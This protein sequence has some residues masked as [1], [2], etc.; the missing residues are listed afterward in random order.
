MS[1]TDR[2]GRRGTLA[3]MALA[4]VAGAVFTLVFWFLAKQ[5]SLPAFST[6]MVTRALAT[7][8]SAAVLVVVGVLLAWWMRGGA[9]PH[10]RRALTYTAAYLSPA[11]LV[12]STTGM[13]LSA[14]R[15]YIDGLQV[16]QAFRTQFLSRMAQTTSLSDMN[17]IDMPTY[18]PPTWF[19]LGG[20]LANLLG[21]PG[22]EVYQPWA[23][24][25]ISA[26][27]C[28]LVPVWQRL[29]GS[30]PAATAIALVSTCLMLQLGPQEPYAI[31]VAL[32][33]PAVS[34][35]ARRALGGSW[36]ATAGVAIFLG[37]SATI[38]TLFTALAA[39]SVVVM[40]LVLAAASKNWRPIAHLVAA[41]TGS[42]L[43]ALITWGPYL[44]AT[45]QNRER[46]GATA[47]HYLPGEGAEFPVPFLAASIVGVLCMVGLVYLVIHWRRPAEGALLLVL[48][49]QY[50]WCL[51]S[52]VFTVGGV[53][54]LGF[55][56]EMVVALQLATAGVMGFAWIRR[57]GLRTLYPDRFSARAQQAV[58][59]ALVVV[60]SF[61]GVKYAQDIPT[62]NQ[63]N[64]DYAYSDTDGYGERADR[65]APNATQYYAQ[66]DQE[67]Q[68]HGHNPADTVVLADETRFMSF[69]PYYGFQAFTSH[70]ANPLGEF[71][72]RNAA[73]EDWATRSWDELADPTTF[74][75]ALHEPAWRA[76]DVF[77]FRGDLEAERD[78]A[79]ETKTGFKLHLAEDIYPNHP[80]VRFKGVFFNPDSFADEKLWDLTQIG[81]FV[82]VTRVSGEAGPGRVVD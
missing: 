17:Y 66:I 11:A 12:F 73:I 31:I 39:G 62:H 27:A 14:T 22:W 23:L 21:M 26:A 40:A 78:A 6:S 47:M 1:S 58:T 74:D 35:I 15:L 53:T 30:L 38:Y 51:A 82:V 18:Y 67:I 59:V 20:R 2:L 77:I 48:L 56:I 49:C 9:I 70:Y 25:S 81:P 44:W 29:L 4:P 69:H 33:V 52:M 37:V 55:R 34:V 57:E 19:W 36:F 76:P 63:E 7:A 42:V 16:D 43:I 60:L 68:R 45:A 79:T 41:G 65:F 5:V 71:D 64:I 10:W 32:G 3:A 28:L 50:A 61:A 46:S 75:A 72:R 24:V 8:G 54:L 80:N 13:P